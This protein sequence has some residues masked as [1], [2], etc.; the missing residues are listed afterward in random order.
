[1]GC[2]VSPVERSRPVV[3]RSRRVYQRIGFQGDSMLHQASFDGNIT[4]VMSFLEYGANV[5]ARGKK[6]KTPLHHAARKGHTK[7]VQPLLDHGADPNARRDDRWTAS[8]LA[9]RYGHLHVLEVLLERGA[10]PHFR[11]N[12]GKTSFQLAMAPPLWAV[13]PNHPQIAQLLWERTGE[14]IEDLR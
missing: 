2:V 1:M 4:A 6:G 3:T 9:A 7:V 14:R 8:H 10:G 5:D 13:K 12:E 11:T